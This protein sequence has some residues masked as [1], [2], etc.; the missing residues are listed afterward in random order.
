MRRGHPGLP[1]H[2]PARLNMLL[3]AFPPPG[4]SPLF[5]SRPTGTRARGVTLGGRPELEVCCACTQQ[6]ESCQPAIRTCPRS[7]RSV[8]ARCPAPRT[9]GIAGSLGLCPW[10]TG[11]LRLSNILWFEFYVKGYSE[12]LPNV[13]FKLKGYLAYSLY[14]N[15][16]SFAIGKCFLHPEYIVG[17]SPFSLLTSIIAVCNLGE[18]FV[19]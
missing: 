19:L 17:L 1:F 16:Y 10:S 7:R 18:N 13:M 3:R 12:S 6:A 9:P 8:C 5:S 14:N 4:I 11:L 15:V 2:W